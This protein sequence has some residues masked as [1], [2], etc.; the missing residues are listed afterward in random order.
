[1]L[2]RFEFH[3]SDFCEL[4]SFM[5]AKPGLVVSSRVRQIMEPI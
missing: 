5:F 3:K 2:T 4:L 1:M